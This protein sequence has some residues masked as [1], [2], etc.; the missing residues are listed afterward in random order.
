M[1]TIGVPP[2]VRS[3]ARTRLRGSLRFETEVN[4]CPSVFLAFFLSSF[5]P[6]FLSFLCLRSR[7]DRLP[8]HLEFSLILSLSL[9]VYLFFPGLVAHA[10]YRTSARKRK[11]DIHGMLP[12][13][14]RLRALVITRHKYELHQSL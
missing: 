11:L 7:S 9:W 3:L 5:L 6:F 4:I 12:R 8:A 2:G 14:W 13:C 10:F 1:T